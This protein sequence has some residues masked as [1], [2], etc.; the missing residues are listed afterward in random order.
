MGP[1]LVT[2]AKVSSEEAS[3][4]TICT[5]AGENVV[6]ENIDKYN[7]ISEVSKESRY[8]RD[9]MRNELKIWW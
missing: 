8:L 3:E 2:V 6:L 1:L 7:T 4:R 9:L 5:R